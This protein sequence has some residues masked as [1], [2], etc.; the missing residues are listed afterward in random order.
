M[1]Q[2]AQATN[3][4]I[5]R[6]RGW[7]LCLFLKHVSG[8]GLSGTHAC[9]G[10]LRMSIFRKGRRQEKSSCQAPGPHPA[11]K[12][13]YGSRTWTTSTFLLALSCSR[14]F[15]LS[16]ACLSSIPTLFRPLRENSRETS[17][18]PDPACRTDDEPVRIL[19]ASPG[20]R[21]GP[22]PPGP[23]DQGLQSWQVQ[24]CVQAC[25]APG[26]TGQCAGPDSHGPSFRKRPWRGPGSRSS[27]G[28]V[29]QGGRGGLARCCLPT[30]ISLGLAL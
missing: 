21:L 17:S 9:K 22:G 28:L 23:G 16:S 30:A 5:A 18:C 29:R 10:P 2:V 27:R 7:G 15:R 20:R 26:R 1:K 8:M 12:K 13:V 4:R 14:T 6:G 19:S 11:R 24:G 25:A 3:L